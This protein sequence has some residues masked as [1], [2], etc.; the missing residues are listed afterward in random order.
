MAKITAVIDIGSNSARMAV[1]KKTSHFGFVL[2]KEIKSRVRISQFAYQNGGYLQD[3][4]M[5]RALCAL[6]EFLMIAKSLKARKILA[7]ATSAVRDAPN[8]SVFLNK[9]KKLLNLN[10]K[11]ISGPKEAWF[12]AIAASNLLP[13]RDGV[14]IDIGGGSTELAVIKNRKITD[15]ISLNLGTVRLKELFFDVHDIEGAKAYIHKELDKLSSNFVCDNVFGIGGTIRAISKAIMKK[16]N[17]SLDI[18]HAFTYT[19]KDEIGF[20][21]K[22]V[23][24]TDLQLKE[25]GFKEDRLDTIKEGALILLC[26]FEKLSARELMTSGV[27]VR[28]GVFLSDLLR[29]DNYMFPPNFNPSVRSVEDIYDVN[30]KIA[31]YESK[32]AGELFDILTPIHNL[33][34][35]YRVYLQ[36]AMKLSTVGEYIDFYS[37]HKHTEYILLNSLHYGFTHKERILISQIIKNHKKKKIK[38]EIPY[39]DLSISKSVLEELCFIFWLTKVLNINLQNPKLQLQL[40]EGILYINGD[41]LYLAREEL[42]KRVARIPIKI[43]ESLE[44]M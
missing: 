33:P 30:R 32:L 13:Y 23:N 22:I 44:T 4:A 12:G 5:D 10:I 41:N 11:V 39:K 6:E 26:V 18:L 43:G 16:N 38:K 3:V 14:T 40:H 2:L 25:M 34:A 1:F 37:S 20:I 17:Y 9:V 36:Y 35:N 19:I 27:G 8:K 42:S 15:T 7:V 31:A 21:S 24:S 29:N 28:E